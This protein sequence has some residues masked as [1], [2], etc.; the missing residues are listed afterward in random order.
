MVLAFCFFV[1]LVAGLEFMIGRADPSRGHHP[2]LGAGLTA[3]LVF[4]LF[5]TT[6]YWAKWLIGILGLCV[7]RIFYALVFK[8]FYELPRNFS[9]REGLAW[10]GYLLAA[11]ALTARHA[12]R[13]P[14]GAEKLGLV[15]FVVCIAMAIALNN[16]TALLYGLGLLAVTEILQRL[17]SHKRPHKSSL[18]RSPSITES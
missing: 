6:R 3:A 5:K 4:V 14:R 8:A 17:A 18:P 10:L 15:S 2:L 9:L 1:A 7:L 13:T 12:S 16:Y 11:F